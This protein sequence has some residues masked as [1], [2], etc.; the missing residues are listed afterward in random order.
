MLRIA[1]I[2]L[3][4]ACGSYV[5]L[6]ALCY[7]FISR[8]FECTSARRAHAREEAVHH[9]KPYLE[10]VYATLATVET[11]RHEYFNITEI[12]NCLVAQD[13]ISSIQIRANFANAIRAHVVCKNGSGCTLCAHI[14]LINHTAKVIHGCGATYEF[15]F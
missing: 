11:D 4:I 14:D 8:V 13:M 9:T 10:D 15:S 1:H 3:A 2:I 7:R 6:R 12:Y 5:I